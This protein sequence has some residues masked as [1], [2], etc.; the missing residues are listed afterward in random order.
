MDTK[1]T[2]CNQ[3]RHRV[4]PLRFQTH[5]AAV[6]GNRLGK[7]GGET[8]NSAVKDRKCRDNPGECRKF[9]ESAAQLFAI[10]GQYA[11]YTATRR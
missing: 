5:Y 11:V 8:C 6:R 7:M 4:E 1:L 9:R 2:E 10:R 3:N